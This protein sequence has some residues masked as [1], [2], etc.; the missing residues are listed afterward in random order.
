MATVFGC[1]L[2]GVLLVGRGTV[3]PQ[4]QDLAERIEAAVAAASPG[5]EIQ[6]V[7]V[8]EIS[9]D[10]VGVVTPYADNAATLRALNV[11]WDAEAA[12]AFRSEAWVELVFIEGDRIV[13]WCDMERRKVDF[14]VLAGPFKV[15]AAT[16]FVV[17]APLD[18]SLGKVLVPSL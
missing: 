2:V 11:P 16:T 4:R 6:L 8:L 5:D 9:F 17:G 18:P 15:P 1:F 12:R 3:P 7:R 10:S 14:P 13:A